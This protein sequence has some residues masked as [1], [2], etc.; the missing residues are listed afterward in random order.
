MSV[1]DLQFSTFDLLLIAVLLVSAIVG[2][3]RGLIRE[4]LSLLSW[5]VSLWMAFKFAPEVST[6]LAP[7][8]DAP[9]LQ[10]VVALAAVFILCL[11]LLSLC[12]IILAKLLALVGIAGTDRSLGAV[13][14]VVRGVAIGV[15]LIFL[16]R[17][18]P[19]SN[20]SWFTSSTLVPYFNPI[21]AFLDQ[22]G[23]ASLDTKNL[24]MPG[25]Q[26]H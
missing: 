16:L 10:Y 4:L 9:Q 18:T 11:L 13:F 14:G 1:A 8:L 5:V 7:Y 22:R 23:Y 20:E 17:L 2:I 19:A 3:V 26:T 12:A 25:I 21:F 6:W 24:T 15:V